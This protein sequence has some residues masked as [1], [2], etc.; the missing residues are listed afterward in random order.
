VVPDYYEGTPKPCMCGWGNI[1]MT[2]SPDGYVLPCLSA[3]ILPELDLP[4][5]RDHKLDWIWHESD[6]FNKY[7][8]EDWM[9][10]PCKSCPQRS[11][12]FGG[13]RCQAYMITG[14][15]RNADPACNL[16]YHHDLVKRMLDPDQKGEA[17]LM[18]NVPNSRKLGELST[19]D[20]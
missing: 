13:C 4:N 10:E 11:V 14:D 20:S 15:A 8:G 16:S 17:L 18:R 7:R 2:I 6:A 5:V 9:L 12:D 3:P 19:S 1:S